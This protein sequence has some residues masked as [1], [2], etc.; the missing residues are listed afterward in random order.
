MFSP[1][2]YPV[3]MRT[4]FGLLLFLA[5]ASGLLADPKHPLTLGAVGFS[6][7]KLSKS[8]RDVAD[9]LS[10]GMG[11]AIT[12]ELFPKYDDVL[13]ALEKKGL[14]LAI[15]TPINF[16]IAEEKLA[17]QPIANPIY[18]SGEGNYRAVILAS[19]DRK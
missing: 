18:Q 2:R 8:V 19:L 9:Y 3:H 15:L 1:I 11:M 6:G 17:V 10:K 4:L 7:E 12:V 14:D 13:Q 5:P 16:L